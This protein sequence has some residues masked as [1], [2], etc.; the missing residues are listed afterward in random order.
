MTKEEI[1][2]RIFELQTD[3]EIIEFVNERLKELED[4]SVERTVGQ[5][6]TD[7]FQDYISEKTHYKAVGRNKRLS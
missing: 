5:G 3:E 7:S 1:K 2:K 4:N 6:Y